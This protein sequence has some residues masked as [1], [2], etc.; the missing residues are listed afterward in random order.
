MKTNRQTYE[1]TDEEQRRLLKSN[2]S[3]NITCHFT[4][5]KMLIRNYCE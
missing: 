1:Y 2:D 5:V 3:G 4:E